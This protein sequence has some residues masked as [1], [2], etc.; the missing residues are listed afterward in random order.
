MSIAQLTEQASALLAQPNV[1]EV[2]VAVVLRDIVKAMEAV[3][4]FDTPCL[5]TCV[6]RH[7][8]AALASSLRA[9]ARL[10]AGV[11]VSLPA[12]RL[13]PRRPC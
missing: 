11:R 12:P 5:C 1:D 10:A 2:A 7:S 4:Q 9:D 13:Y 6:L 3:N 8:S